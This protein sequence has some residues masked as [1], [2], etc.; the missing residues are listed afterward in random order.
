[1]LRTAALAAVI[2]GAMAFGPSNDPVKALEALQQYAEKEYRNANTRQDFDAAVIRVTS[3]AKEAV[4]GVEPSKIEAKDGYMWAQIFEMAKMPKEATTSVERFLGT[5]STEGRF[6]AQLLVMNLYSSQGELSKAR[7]ALSQIKPNSG[8]DTA[9]LVFTVSNELADRV[10]AKEGVDAGA[11]ILD[12]L[13]KL[14]KLKGVTDAVEVQIGEGALYTLASTRVQF[15]NEAHR[16]D[17]SLKALDDATQLLDPNSKMVKRFHTMRNQITVVGATAPELKAERGYGVFPGL[18]SLKGKV[19]LVDFF[20]HWCGPCKAAFP[21]MEKLY[22]DLHDKG[23]E[24]VGFTTYYGYYGKEMKLTPDVEFG[25]MDGFIKQYNLPWPIQFGDRSNFE[26]YGVTGIP[27]V[28]VIDR[29]GVVRKLHIGYSEASFGEFRD[30][31]EKLLAE[32]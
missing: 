21:Q 4:G 16:K 5:S 29:S 18:N 2:M 6:D 10:K 13:Q 22:A 15:Y 14:I 23:L 12:S 1:M 7:E 3:K 27:H 11:R 31:V 32:K 30:E 24:I 19:V 9:R 25:K 17:D 20:A 28:A 26:N 8:K